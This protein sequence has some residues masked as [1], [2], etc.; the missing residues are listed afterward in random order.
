M[1]L[2]G[3]YDHNCSLKDRVD[4]KINHYGGKKSDNKIEEQILSFSDLTPIEKGGKTENGRVAAP[5]SVSIYL[6]T[7]YVTMRH[8]N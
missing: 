6:K 4:L 2:D 8:I 3:A 1:H 7:C 5:E